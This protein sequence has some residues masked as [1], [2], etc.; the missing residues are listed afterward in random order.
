MM[1]SLEINSEKGNDVSF[2]R[3]GFRAQAKER[4]AKRNRNAT[5]I[6]RFARGKEP[7]LVLARAYC[8]FQA[9]S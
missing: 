1:R 3:S 5:V 6:S 2:R 7:L 8:R 9:L 4:Q